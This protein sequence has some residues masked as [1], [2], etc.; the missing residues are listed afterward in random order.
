MVDGGHA[1]R[2]RLGKRGKFRKGRRGN[3]IKRQQPERKEKYRKRQCPANR[4]QHPDLFELS[5]R[6][7]TQRCDAMTLARAFPSNA[8]KLT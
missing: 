1:V 2:Q 6:H 8:N 3:H 5:V 4:K 7:D